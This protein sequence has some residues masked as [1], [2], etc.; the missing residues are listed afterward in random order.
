[1]SFPRKTFNWRPLGLAIG[2][3]IVI[4]LALAVIAR[5]APLDLDHRLV[6][7]GYDGCHLVAE[8]CV[9][10]GC[11]G[12]DPLPQYICEAM[13]KSLKDNGIEAACRRV[14]PCLSGYHP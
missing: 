9:P 14:E 13:V 11:R 10:E 6:V 5:A 7:C 8:I 3:A 12:I 2:L 4:V 1:M